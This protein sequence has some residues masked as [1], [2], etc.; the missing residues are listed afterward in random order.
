MDAAARDCDAAASTQGRLV[1]SLLR[2]LV[3]P[4]PI[5]VTQIRVSPH[6]AGNQPTAKR[7]RGRPPSRGG[8]K[9]QAE[10]Q[11]AYRARL[12]AQA[13]DAARYSP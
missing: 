10:I 4:I 12:A 8:P 3:T 9:P 7:L 5:R 13:A 2:F 11:Q 1:P 6:R